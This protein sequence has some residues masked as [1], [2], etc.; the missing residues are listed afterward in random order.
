MINDDPRPTRTKTTYSYSPPTDDDRPFLTVKGS[1]VK[2]IDETNPDKEDIKNIIRLLERRIKH[3]ERE[4]E[5]FRVRDEYTSAHREKEYLRA[6]EVRDQIEVLETNL[7]RVT[8]ENKK[9]IKNN[10]NLLEI[11]VFPWTLKTE[12]QIVYNSGRFGDM[13][14]VTPTEALEHKIEQQVS[15]TDDP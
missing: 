7:K 4:N 6:K 1:F 2:Y 13:D 5:V 10:K 9:L 3:L 12:K 15:D 14:I 11:G 8:T